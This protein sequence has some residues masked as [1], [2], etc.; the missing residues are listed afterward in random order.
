[1]PAKTV[2]EIFEVEN[3]RSWLSV[4]EYDRKLEKEV[5]KRTNV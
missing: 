5:L 1:L 3:K 4:E 2:E